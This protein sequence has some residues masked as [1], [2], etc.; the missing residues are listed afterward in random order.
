MKN[1]LMVGGHNN[2]RSCM[3][4]PQIGKVENHLTEEEVWDAFGV[5]TPHLKD[6]SF[7][8]P[9]QLLPHQSDMVVSDWLTL[10]EKPEARGFAWLLLCSLGLVLL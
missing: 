6:C 4:G 1:N 7:L 2:M 3:K 5:C 8:A 9:S 10:H